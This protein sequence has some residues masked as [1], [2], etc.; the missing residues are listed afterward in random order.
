[1]LVDQLRM[2]VATQQYAEIVE[3]CHDALQL[4]SVDQ[5]IVRGVLLLRT[6]FRKVSCRFCERSAA[7]VLF[8]FLSRAPSRD[9]MAKSLAHAGV[10]I[11]LAVFWIVQSLG[12]Q[13]PGWRL[14][15]TRRAGASRSWR[16]C[17]ILSARDSRPFGVAVE[18]RRRAE[19][20][21]RAFR[22]RPASV[23]AHH[24][25][26]DLAGGRHKGFARP[27]SLGD[28]EWALLKNKPLSFDGID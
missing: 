14:Q 19:P 2:P 10:T 15:G 9:V 24:R 1:M 28:G 16:Q 7:I 17:T 27:M 25:H 8:R 11:G 18:S 5:N 4:D 22:Y 20:P 3:P 26:D 21:A 23:D 6:W 13:G 12:E